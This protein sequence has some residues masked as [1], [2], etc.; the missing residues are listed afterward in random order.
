MKTILTIATAAFMLHALP[1]AA[2]QGAQ[3]AEHQN[4]YRTGEQMA[5]RNK[6]RSE[7]TH[8]EQRREQFTYRNAGPGFGVPRND[9]APA[10]G[11]GGYSGGGKGKGG[12]R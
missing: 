5:E 7:N 9:P 1:A 8:R 3:G 10:W 12:W 4:R 2:Q 11:A 6:Q